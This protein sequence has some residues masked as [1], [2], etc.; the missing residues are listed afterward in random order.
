MIH[1][2]GNVVLSVAA[3][4]DLLPQKYVILKWFPHF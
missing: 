2:F 4:P 3:I 1:M